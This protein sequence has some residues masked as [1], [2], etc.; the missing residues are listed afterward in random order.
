MLVWR[1]ERNGKGPFTGSLSGCFHDHKIPQDRENVWHP[2]DEDL[3]CTLLS[4]GGVCSW[5]SKEKMLN[6]PLGPATV[7]KLQDKMFQVIVY[8]VPVNDHM[9]HC[10]DGQV[11]LNPLHATVVE[12]YEPE[13]FFS[14]LMKGFY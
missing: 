14:D 3:V 7:R 4:D 1:I 10:V 5:D 13:V 9:Y 8:D 2:D 11:I 6:F 12:T